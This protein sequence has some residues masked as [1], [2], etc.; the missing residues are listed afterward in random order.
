MIRIQLTLFLDNF[1]ETIEKIRAQYNPEQ[2]NY[3]AY[4]PLSGKRNRANQKNN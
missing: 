3:I 4:S 1:K 2:F